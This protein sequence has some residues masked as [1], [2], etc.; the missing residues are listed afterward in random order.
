MRDEAPGAPLPLPRGIPGFAAR[1]E[2]S[3]L[4]LV[5]LALA[6]VAWFVHD[7]QALTGE[8][9][10]VPVDDTYI[11]F[12]FAQNLASGH[13]FAFNPGQSLPGSTSPL[14][15]VLLALAGRCGVPLW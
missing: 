5:V 15:V 7:Q 11:H 1:S 12:R 13:G 10:G 14:W 9:W 3:A 6:G 8:L 4:V 2:H